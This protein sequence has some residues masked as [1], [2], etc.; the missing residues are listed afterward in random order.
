MEHSEHFVW[1]PPA[2]SKNSNTRTRRMS[3]AMRGRHRM[4]EVFPLLSQK[5]QG[6]AEEDA[7][8]HGLS[9]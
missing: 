2:G 9:R 4:A 6:I 5:G 3:L 7:E 1:Q 8:L